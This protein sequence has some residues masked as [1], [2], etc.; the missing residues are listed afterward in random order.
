MKTI[1]CDTH[2]WPIAFLD[3][4]NHPD[5]GTIERIDDETVAF[6]R[7]GALI[8]RFKD[9]RWDLAKR[10]T[11]MDQDGFDIQVL[12]P[13]NRPFLYEL[14]DRLGNAMARAFN[15]FAAD[16]VKD[17]DRFIAVSWIY[18]P[19]MKGAV[20]ELRRSIEELGIK[21]VKLT[22]GINDCD[23]DHPSMWPLYEVAEHHDVPILVHPAARAHEDQ[24][25]HPW[26]IGAG[27]YAP[28]RFLSSTLGFPFSYMHSITRLIYSGVMDRFPK[29]RVGMFEGGA[30]WVP[31]LRNQLDQEAK[32]RSFGEYL[33]KENLTLRRKPSE[34]FDQFYIAAVSYEP[35]IASTARDWGADHKLIIGSDFDHADPIATWPD[36]VRT[37]RALDGLSRQDQDRILCTNAAELLGSQVA[38]LAA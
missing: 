32:H 8:H 18:L 4:V 20:K 38:A 31:F 30:G 15:D 21:A 22:G 25:T 2:Y 13:D 19:D 23:L 36:T 26:L 24:I 29:L 3:Q 5:K 14:D 27:R 12:I 10:K 28:M 11:A 9:T 17:E 6:Y 16:A 35:Y 33:K 34:Y 7:D 1:D 37:L